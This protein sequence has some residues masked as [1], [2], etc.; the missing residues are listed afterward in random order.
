MEPVQRKER[1]L[2]QHLIGGLIWGVFMFVMVELVFKLF[3]GEPIINDDLF[4]NIV[5]WVIIC[6]GAFGLANFYIA[7]YLKKRAEKKELSN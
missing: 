1:T 5:W 3:E 7:K 6:G 2:K 4:T